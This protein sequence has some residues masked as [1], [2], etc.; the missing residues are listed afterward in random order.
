LVPVQC[1]YYALEGLGQLLKTVQLVRQTLNPTLGLEGI[2][3]TMFDVRNN[4]CNQVAREIQEHF[5]R[6]V[7]QTIVPRNVSLAEAPSHGGPVLLYDIAS[8]GAQAYLQLAKEVIR[9]A[10]KGIR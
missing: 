6:R 10:E 7:F 1:E 9:Y 8:R 3:L 5:D 2:L 4:L